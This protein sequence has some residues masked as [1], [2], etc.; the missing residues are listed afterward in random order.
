MTVCVREGNCG[1]SVGDV[2]EGKLLPART[3]KQKHYLRDGEQAREV[4]HSSTHTLLY[5]YIY[6]YILIHS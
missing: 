5:I 3:V 6:T 1:D 2:I 4:R